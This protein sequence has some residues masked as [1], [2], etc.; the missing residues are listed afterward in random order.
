[1]MAVDFMPGNPPNI[2]H[3]RPPFD[4]DATELALSCAPARCFGV[5]SDGQHFYTMRTQR[6]PPPVVTQINIVPNWFEELRAKV[7]SAPK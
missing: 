5:A 4:F 3:P 2:G 6:A 1:M 7:P